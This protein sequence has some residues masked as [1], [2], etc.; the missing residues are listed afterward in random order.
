[1]HIIWQETHFSY[2]TARDTIAR[3]LANPKLD[4]QLEMILLAKEI[5]RDRSLTYTNGGQLARVYGIIYNRLVM[6]K[7]GCYSKNN[8]STYMEKNLLMQ[9]GQ[10]TE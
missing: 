1:M 9:M 8:T 5:K 2:Q 4:V 10:N 7:T 3:L 6:E